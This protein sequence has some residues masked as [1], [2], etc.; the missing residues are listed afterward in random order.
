M[1]GTGP[2]LDPPESIR[3][4]GLALALAV[5]LAEVVGLAVE[6]AVAEGLAVAL[7]EGSGDDVAWEGGRSSQGMP[8]L[9]GSRL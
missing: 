3:E 1:S 8:S 6:L 5:G 9:S 2:L 7:V 4:P